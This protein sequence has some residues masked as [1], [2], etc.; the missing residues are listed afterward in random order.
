M[1]IKPGN[2]V[3]FK[4]GEEAKV[5]KIIKRNDINRILI[6]FDKKVVGFLEEEASVRNYWVYLLDGKFDSILKQGN[7]IVKVIPC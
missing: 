3:I 4:N 5:V 2:V 7:N 1:N 6:Y